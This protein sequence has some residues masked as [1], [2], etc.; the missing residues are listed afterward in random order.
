MTSKHT[1]QS[2]PKAR[3]R[4][5]ALNARR[6]VHGERAASAASALS[7]RL[8]ADLRGA[9]K[10]IAGYWPLGD[11][12]DCRLA[13]ENYAVKDVRVALPVVAGQGQVLVFRRWT[14][15]E[16]LEAGPF[17]TSHPLASA[18][19]CSPDVLLIPLVAFDKIGQR[20]GYGAGYYDRTLAELRAS[21]H[22]VLAIGVG[23]DEQEIESIPAGRHD[24][25]MD[26]VVTDKRT[27]WFNETAPGN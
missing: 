18:P 6:I 11:E 22:Q 9:D 16:S 19:V 26:A 20:L 5:A 7:E 2:D 12:I 8:L 23:Y 3:L 10:L 17:G 4:R 14:P 15:G 25:R 24:E 1:P 21:G 13:L 27:I